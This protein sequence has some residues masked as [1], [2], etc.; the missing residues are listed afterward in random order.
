MSE[1]WAVCTLL[2]IN[3]RQSYLFLCPCSSLLLL[4]DMYVMQCPLDSPYFNH[5][6]CAMPHKPGLWWLSIPVVG[7]WFV[8]TSTITETTQAAALP[9]A[10]AHARVSKC[11]D[12]SKFTCNHHSAIA[13][14]ELIPP[15]LSLSLKD[16]AFEYV[17]IENK[18]PHNWTTQEVYAT[19]TICGEDTLRLRNL[20]WTRQ[21]C[22][23]HLLFLKLFWKK[24]GVKGE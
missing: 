21:S 12:W 18:M 15:S 13:H 20:A 22:D 8:K 24:T 9:L 7:I 11:T 5:L 14:Y 17:R 6:L 3:R 19:E 4:L 16:T 23:L 2:T 10:R 1:L